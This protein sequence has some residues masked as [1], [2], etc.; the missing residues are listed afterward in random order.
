[1]S[2]VRSPVR[3]GARRGG[4]VL[5]YPL[6]SLYREIA[7]IAYHFHWSAEEVAN[8]EHPDRRRWVKEISA[9]NERMQVE[10]THVE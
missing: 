8:F 5:G 1:M 10:P 2:E 6:E 7:F 3:G 9:I 4:G